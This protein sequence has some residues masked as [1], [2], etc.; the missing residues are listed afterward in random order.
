MIRAG[1]ILL[2]AVI[3]APKRTAV[4]LAVASEDGRAHAFLLQT[5]HRHAA[6][7]LPGR[8]LRL[9]LRGLPNGVYAVQVDGRV[10]GRLVIGA[11]PGP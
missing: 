4:A 8:P 9:L 3:G 11:T 6:R 7:V 10:R 1:G 5:P 2:P